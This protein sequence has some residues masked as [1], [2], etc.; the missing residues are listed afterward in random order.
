MPGRMLTVSLLLYDAAAQLGALAGATGCG[1]AAHYAEVAAGVAAGVD[2]LFDSAGGSG[3]FLASDGLE[4]APDVFGSAYL[5]ALGLST[6]ERRAGV[7]GFLA[8]QWRNSTAAAAGPGGAAATTTTIWQEGQARHL[9]YPLVWK[10]CWSGC[11]SP[12]TYQNGGER[13]YRARPRPTIVATAGRCAFVVP[14][15]TFP[16]LPL[17]SHPAPPAAAFWATPLNWLLPALTL[18]GFDAEAAQIAAAA[19]ASFQKGGVMEA[20]NR[21]IGYTGVRDY[22]ASACN[23]LGA[24]APAA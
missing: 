7:A 22:V 8:A 10:Q 2:A 6:P 15:T 21:D 23:V 16:A 13:K 24:V 19:I 11:P 1:D 5:A 3:L 20:I 9:P 18:N 14:L 4:D 17:P 12:G